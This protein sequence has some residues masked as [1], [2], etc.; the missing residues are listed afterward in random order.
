[1]NN[2]RIKNI[3]SA[4]LILFC[5][6]AAAVGISGCAVFD[7]SIEVS[8]ITVEE[9]QRRKD[10]ATDP[11]GNFSRASTYVMLQSVS[12][13]SIFSAVSDNLIELKY[14][15]P[16][17]VKC[18][19]SKDGKALSGYIIDG[20]SAWNIDYQAKKVTPIAPQHMVKMRTLT[21]LNTPATRYKDVFS[22]VEIY[23]VTNTDGV[24]YKLKCYNNPDNLFEIYIDAASYLTAR[25][26][27]SFK[28]P[29]GVMKS[30][31]VMKSYTLYEGIRIPDESVSMTGDDEQR[32]KV[33]QYKLNVPLDDSEFK[34]PVL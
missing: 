21:K 19:I 27:T 12:D 31:S 30:D 22:N 33:I 34:A 4:A 18:T 28:L 14:K 24:F 9:L 8:D 1:M 17:K 32:Q 25:M 3:F 20:E 11:A 29:S 15:R 5:A 6:V 26:K 2:C 23:K 10:M 16:D 7:E 13:N